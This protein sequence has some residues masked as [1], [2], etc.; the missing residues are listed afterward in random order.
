MPAFAPARPTLL[1]ADDEPSFAQAL[2]HSLDQHGFEVQIAYDG[3]E[4]LKA[5]DRQVPDYAVIDLRLP[6][7]SGLKLVERLRARDAHANV[8]VLTGY[9][10]IATAIHAVKLGATYY[11][12][13]PVKAGQIV[14]AFEL[15]EGSTE[16][17]LPTKPLS[18]DRLTWEHIQEVLSR[19]GGNVSAAARDLN[20]HRR[21]LQRKLG[22][23]APKD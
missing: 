1:L 18:V 6:D 10:S 9:G 20:M 11:L 12:T 13:K 19:V 4:A 8:V 7:M 16:V 17:G 21:T 2:A 14:A 22:K 5:I 3:E 15:R 23:Y